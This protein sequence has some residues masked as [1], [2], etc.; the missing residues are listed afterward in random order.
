VS[1]ANVTHPEE[2][3]CFY[4]ALS[5]TS[6]FQ[7]ASA[8]GPF[9]VDGRLDK[10]AQADI[11]EFVVSKRTQLGDRTPK[12]AFSSQIYEPLMDGEI[13][14][15]ELHPAEPGTPLRGTL[16]TVSIDFIH[17]AREEQHTQPF[18]DPENT[19]RRTLTYKRH[20]N[21]AVT[22]ATG[23]PLWYTA[24][25][26]VWGAPVFDQIINFENG[27]IKITPSLT[28]ALYKLRSTE[29]GVFLWIDQICINQPDI[30]E[31]VQQIPLMGMI[32]TH[33]TNTIIWLGDD[34]GSDPSLAFDLMETVYARLQGTDAQ[35]TP[36][37]FQRL[38]FP[39]VLDQSWWAI[40]QL[41]RRPWMGRLWTIQEAVL[42]KN[43]IAKS[44][45]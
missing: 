13:R 33:A 19:S 40:R 30:A 45:A 22:L 39:P 24:L 29:Y 36:A 26:Y 18:D 38:A 1:F 34:D 8:R 11:H 21:H 27:S 28:S 44:S 4:S 32:Y 31:K 25:S 5:K 43:Y 42:S 16:H 9:G 6:I 12:T 14:V 10:L 41:L 23:E 3:I 37:D 2:C 35:V 15:L 20:T 17:P 7:V